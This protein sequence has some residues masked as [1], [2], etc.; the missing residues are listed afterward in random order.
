MALVTTVSRTEFDLSVI[1]PGYVFYGK[2]KYWDEGVA[3]IVTGANVDEIRV[4]FRPAISNVTNHYFVKAQEIA[5]G[6]WEDV[7]WSKD[8]KDVYQLGADTDPATDDTKE[9]GTDEP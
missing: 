7:R 3:G 1:E 5:D 2:N 4:Q 9:D 6:L 8:L